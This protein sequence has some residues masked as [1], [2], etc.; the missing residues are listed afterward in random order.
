MIRFSAHLISVVFHPLLML[1]YMLLLMLVV[2]PYMFG[3]NHLAEADNLIVMVF[4]TSALIPLI[5]ILVM[6]G[7]GWVRSLQMSDRHERIGPYIVTAVLYLTLYLHLS[8]ARVFPELLLVATLGTV[9]ALFAGFFVNN[10][11]KVSMHATAAGGLLGQTGLLYSRFST[12]QFIL[13]LP[14]MS[15]LQV[16]TLYLL[17]GV[18]LLAGGICTARLIGKKHAP[19]EIYMGLVLGVVCMVIAKVILLD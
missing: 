3:Y 13:P 4:L 7:I 2:N 14:G 11:R 6:K 9:F 8:K 5:A 17:Y 1:T 16:P 18:I 19:D 12:D 10:F 15:E